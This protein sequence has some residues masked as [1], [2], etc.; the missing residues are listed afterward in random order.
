MQELEYFKRNKNITKLGV[1]VRDLRPSTL[2]YSLV[3]LA[4]KKVSDL[5]LT[6]FHNDWHPGMITNNVSQMQYRNAYGF[7][8]T[9][10]STDIRTALILL[11]L[12]STCKKLFYIW[13]MYEYQNLNSL[14]EVI[15]L[16]CDESLGLV[17]RSESYRKIVELNFN[18]VGK[19]PKE[20]VF[21]AN[22]FDSP[23]FLN[24]IRNRS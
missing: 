16:F 21:V 7:D 20:Q 6:V 24:I 9:L 22:D 18:R 23:E 15:E 4:N 14:D 5:E 3:E 17:V 10:V 11:N 1:L 2:T 8:G 12:P 13:D 19:T